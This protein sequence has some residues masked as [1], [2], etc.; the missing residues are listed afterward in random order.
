VFG[1]TINLLLNQKPASGIITEV[2]NSTTKPEIES[3][4]PFTS[5]PSEIMTKF[6][7]VS[8]AWNI[9]NIQLA[10]SAAIFCYQVA[11]WVADM[12]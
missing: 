2:E 5:H 12:F 8:H 6:K 11:A 10:K 3:W 4:N 9:S 7:N 1:T